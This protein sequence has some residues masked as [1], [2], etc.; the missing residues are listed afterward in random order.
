MSNTVV[1]PV[2]GQSAPAAPAAP[3]PA[4]PA[5]APVAPPAPAAAA[6]PPVAPDAPAQPDPMKEMEA[7]EAR[8]Q[9]R[10]AQRAQQQAPEVSQDAQVNEYKQKIAEYEHRMGQVVT[11]VQNL[12]HQPLATLRAIGMKDEAIQRMLQNMQVEGQP[13]HQAYLETQ[14]LRREVEKAQADNKKLREDLL[15]ARNQD[16]TWAMTQA[17][18]RSTDDIF[19]TAL[20]ALPPE[21]RA[22]PAKHSPLFAIYGQNPQEMYQDA[23]QFAD[24]YREHH[25]AKICPYDEIVRYLDS[26]ARR[27]AASRVEALAPILGWMKPEAPAP[28]PVIA[29]EA[30]PAAPGMTAAEPPKKT[31]KPVPGWKLPREQQLKRADEELKK[32]REARGQKG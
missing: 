4:T 30:A 15:A 24:A 9:K 23:V 2:N 13:G 5:A 22:D 18:Q 6:V 19:A 27:D 12:E 7:I 28:A 17:Q 1:V 16:V 32:A 11:A 14:A 3:A 8:I 26:K 21:H 10:Q 20:Q 29:S 25:G 31:E